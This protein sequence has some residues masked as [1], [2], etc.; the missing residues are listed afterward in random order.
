MSDFFGALAVV[1]E[2]TYPHPP[3]S[4]GAIE[5]QY[6]GRVVTPGEAVGQLRSGVFIAECAYL[7]CPASPDVQR[8]GSFEY[9]Q[10]NHGDA[11]P[12]N[13]YLF[14]RSKR[15]VEDA[16]GNKRPAIGNANQGR[17]AGL[18]IG[19]AHDGTQRQ[20]AMGRRHG[21]HVINFSVGAAPVIIGR[22]IPTGET[23][24]HIDRLRIRRNHNRRFRRNRWR[25]LRW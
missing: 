25:N 4:N 19:Y 20:S 5:A 23:G 24:L 3:I 2:N 13:V 11:R 16:S 1:I 18:E 17:I 6:S 7:H 10:T 15:K 9:F 14:G 12:P 8:S 21:I 22:T